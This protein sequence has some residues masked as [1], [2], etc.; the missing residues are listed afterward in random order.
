MPLL[1]QAAVTS[2]VIAGAGGFGLEVFDYLNGETAHGAPPVAGFIDDTPGGKV[3]AGVD[4]PWLGDIA[5]FRAA[6]GQVVVVATGSPHGRQII[7]SRLWAKGIATPAYA[8]GS[9]MVSPAATLARGV[10]VC[11]FTIVNRAASIDEGAVVNVFCSVGH[12][13]RIGA[14]SSL[15][16]YAALNGDARI[17]RACFLGTRATIYPRVTIGEECVVDTHTGVRVNAGDRQMISSRGTYKVSPL[18]GR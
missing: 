12:G 15:S 5:G 6:A 2:I 8:H 1:D 16:P 10:T 9:A 17:G 7:L 14:F 3:P 13:A 11:P 18:R 4:R